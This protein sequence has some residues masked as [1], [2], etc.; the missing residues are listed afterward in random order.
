MQDDIWLAETIAREVDRMGGAVYYVGGYVRDRVLGRESKDVD[1]EVH[2]VDI[3]ALV[4]ILERLG[5]VNTIGASFGILS[6]KGY[7]LDISVPRREDAEGRGDRNALST[8]A[9]PY[10]GTY[11]AALRRDLTM[12]ALY[13]NVLSG[14]IVDH[15][16]GLEDIAHGI[17]RHV[18]PASFAIDPLRV[19]RVAQFAARFGMEVDASTTKLCSRIDV[20]EVAPERIQEELRKALCK[21]PRPSRFFE[22]LRKMNRVE[23][24]F[25]ELAALEGVRQNPRYHPEGDVWTHTML[26]MDAAADFRSQATDDFGFMLAALCHDF[27]KALATRELDGRLVSYGHETMGLEPAAC[28]LERLLVGTKVKSYVLNMVELHMA[29][30]GLVAQGA[31][32]KAYNRLFD[33]SCC[34]KDL[35]LLAEAD[36]LGSGGVRYFAEIEEKL[37]RHLRAFEE[38]M[39]RPHVQGR[40]LIAAGVEPGPLMGEILR[41]A[42][43]MRLSGVSKDIALRQCLAAYRKA[44]ETESVRPESGPRSQA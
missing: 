40:D 23:P 9:D 3:D 33:R 26:V 21:A 6:L 2:G 12:N 31:K 22:E 15:F 27:G 4:H 8:C 36:S 32:Q 28:L 42:H 11:K 1:I 7:D 24:W 29:P 25:A 34:P 10:L 44:T 18:D 14:E 5:Q 19:L 16:G 43:K 35:L 37:T 41:F 38:L 39:A 13:Q 30:H 17:I 20:S